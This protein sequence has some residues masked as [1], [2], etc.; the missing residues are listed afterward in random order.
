VA[1]SVQDTRVFRGADF[2]NTDHRLVLTKKKLRLASKCEQKGKRLNVVDLKNPGKA[3]EFDEDC[4]S[5]FRFLKD[6]AHDLE[7]GERPLVSALEDWQ[8]KCVVL[9][10]A[11]ERKAESV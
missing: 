8:K 6:E 3:L 7:K 5:R 9:Y 10:H 1:S 4:G 11:W 2:S